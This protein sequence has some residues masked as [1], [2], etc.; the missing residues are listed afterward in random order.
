[1]AWAEAYLRTK[2]HLDPPSRLATIDMGRK[3]GLCPLLER[4]GSPSNTMSPRPRPTSVPSGILIQ[5]AVWPQQ[6]WAENWGLCPF[7][8]RELGPHLTQCGRGRGLPPCQVSSWSIQPFGHNTP[9]SQ[10]DRQ[11]I[12]STER[13]VLQT[14]AQTLDTHARLTQRFSL[15]YRLCVC[16]SVN[17][18]WLNV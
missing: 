14:V 13:T 18:L 7:R 11:Q 2:W 1:V 6:T 3:V 4:A 12:D 17:V 16:V 5:P 10:T 9:T 15:S 8:E